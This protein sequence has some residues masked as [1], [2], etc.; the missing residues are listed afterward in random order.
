[1]RDSGVWTCLASAK[2]ELGAGGQQMLQELH[3]P[4]IARRESVLQRAVDVQQS[5]H[6]LRDARVLRPTTD[7]ENN[8]AERYKYWNRKGR[9]PE[10]IMGSTLVAGS[11]RGIT[12][13]L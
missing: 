12:N 13:S 3:F 1:M 7:L 10:E 9:G 8:R 4:G 11:R 6:M 5:Q 2:V